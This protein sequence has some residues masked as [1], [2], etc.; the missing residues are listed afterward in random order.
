MHEVINLEV[1]KE[2]DPCINGLNNYIKHHKDFEGSIIDFLQLDNVPV[3]DKFWVILREEFLPTN[4]IHRFAIYCAKEVLHNFESVY[5]KDDRP[6]KAIEAKELYLDGKITLDELNIA[7]SAASAA[8]RSAASAAARSA[9]RSAA[10]A[11][12]YV[13]AAASAAARS[14]ASAAVS[15]AGYV[16]AAASA[17]V[18][19]ASDAARPASD[20]QLNE[21][22][23]IFGEMV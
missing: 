14:A 2:L 13:S 18:R 12:G 3:D 21:L 9:A 20:K 10:S 16:S 1:I 5:P 6:R 23:K 19:S 4:L 17:A 15:A 11:A 22:I 8:A 7:R